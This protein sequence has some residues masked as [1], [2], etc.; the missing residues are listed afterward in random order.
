MSG[1]S[2]RRATNVSEYIQNLNQIPSAADLAAQQNQTGFEGL[3]EDLAPFM[4][5]EFLDYD[6][7]EMGNPAMSI[8]FDAGQ[9]RPENATAQNNNNGFDFLNSKYSIG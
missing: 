6:A 3:D 7:G 8:P 2:G 4:N 5:T 9:T 1:Y